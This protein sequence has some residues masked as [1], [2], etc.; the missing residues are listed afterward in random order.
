MEK[1]FSK[2]SSDLNGPHCIEERKLLRSNL[3]WSTVLCGLAI[4]AMPIKLLV[5][6]YI[7]KHDSVDDIDTEEE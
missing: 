5:E 7:I 3:I 6:S 4:V 1:G 2:D